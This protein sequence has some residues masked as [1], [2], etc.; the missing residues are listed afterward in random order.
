MTLDQSLS[1]PLEFRRSGGVQNLLG[2]ALPRRGIA[3]IG[4]RE[5]VFDH[6][7]YV[8]ELSAE[9][10]RRLLERACFAVDRRSA[11]PQPIVL[12]QRQGHHLEAVFIRIATV[13]RKSRGAL[14]CNFVIV[15]G[16][17]PRSSEQTGHLDFFRLRHT[18]VRGM[19][20]LKFPRGLSDRLLL[21][22]IA[23]HAGLRLL[24]RGRSGALASLPDSVQRRN[25]TPSL[26]GG[27]FG[28]GRRVA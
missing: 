20:D 11:M 26:I 10:F 6:F 1:L 9:K 19:S 23:A 13:G 16:G 4:D 3:S 25:P 7:R 14:Q 28:H 22:G 18:L 5:L 27:G 2:H 15:T 21:L 12:G 17:R 8:S 24:D